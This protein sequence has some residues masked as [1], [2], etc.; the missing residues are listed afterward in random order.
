MINRGYKN[1]SIH[2]A[3][4]KWL[5]QQATALMAAFIEND[6]ETETQIYEE[7]ITELNWKFK[8]AQQLPLPLHT[9]NHPHKS[10]AIYSQL[11]LWAA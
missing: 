9:H 3:R 2:S 7:T 6:L 4:A 8:P 11:N 10:V 1:Y 5:G